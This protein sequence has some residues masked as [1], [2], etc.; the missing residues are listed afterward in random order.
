MNEDKL[1]VSSKQLLNDISGI[2]YE[3]GNQ[4]LEQEHLLLAMLR[5][6]DGLIGKLI[7][8]MEIDL[9]AFTKR[10]EKAVEK[11]VKVQGGELRAGQYLMRALN[12]AEDEARSM[13]DEYTA[14]EHLF[15]GLIKAPNSEIKEIF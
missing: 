13:G 12:A 4:E 1:T 7:E 15:L 8:K 6:K 3:Y 10:A 2:A 5:A 11:R 9:G 14:T